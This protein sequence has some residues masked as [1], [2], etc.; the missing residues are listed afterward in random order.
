M[1]VETQF[2]IAYIKPADN[3]KVLHLP[4]VPFAG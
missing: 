3:E 2:D 1:V 4:P